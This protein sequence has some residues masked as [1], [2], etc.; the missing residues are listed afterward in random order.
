MSQKILDKGA[1]ATILLDGT[2]VI[3]DRVKKDYKTN[4]NCLQ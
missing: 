2:E 3:K 4:D 1:E